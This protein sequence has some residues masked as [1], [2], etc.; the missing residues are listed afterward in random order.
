MF[1]IGDQRRLLSWL[2]KST[3]ALLL[4]R[5]TTQAWER[6]GNLCRKIVRWILKQLFFS[7]K[8]TFLYVRRY[9]LWH[10]VA[11]HLHRLWIL[12]RFYFLFSCFSHALLDML[13][14][15]LSFLSFL[16][17]ISLFLR[18]VLTGMYCFLFHPHTSEVHQYDILSKHSVFLLFLPF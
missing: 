15:S 18:W 6:L 7:S 3:D 17:D 2:K 11:P 10:S 13:L 14:S 12:L 5:L 8:S 9:F 16:A 1:L 4:T